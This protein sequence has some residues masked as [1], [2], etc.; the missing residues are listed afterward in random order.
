M[1]ILSAAALI[2]LTLAGYSSGVALA[3]RQRPFLPTVLDLLLVL[4]LWTAAFWLRGSALNHWLLVGIGLLLGLAVGYAATAA[5]LGRVDTRYVIPKSELPAHAREAGE[6]A[7]APNLLKRLWRRWNDFAGVMGNIQARLIMGFFYF[8][9][10]TPFGLVSRFVS[11]PLA[12]RQAYD[13]SGWLPKH[14]TD[15]HIDAAKEQG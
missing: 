9:F 10:V 4:L 12:T 15:T 5:R 1:G 13:A 8:I 6:T 3:S 2:L 11:D 14:A 7:V